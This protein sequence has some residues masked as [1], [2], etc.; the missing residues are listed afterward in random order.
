MERQVAVSNWFTITRGRYR[1]VK[2][3]GFSSSTGEQ[4]PKQA[5][6]SGGDQSIWIF[7]IFLDFFGVHL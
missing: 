2:V 5:M 4:H 3:G 6:C 7:S 1:R